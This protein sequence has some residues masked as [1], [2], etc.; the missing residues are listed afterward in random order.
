[1]D[2]IDGQGG[3]GGTSGLLLSASYEA[4]YIG[5]AGSGHP[6]PI[7]PWVRD[8]CLVETLYVSRFSVPLFETKKTIGPMQ[9]KI[10]QRIQQKQYDAL[11]GHLQQCLG[12]DWFVYTGGAR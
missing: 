3:E 8:I 7:I 2:K 10:K 4:G 6:D 1:M 5:T 12:L 9:Q 11:L